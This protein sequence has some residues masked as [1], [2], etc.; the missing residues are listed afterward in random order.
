MPPNDKLIWDVG[1]HR[2]L[3]VITGEIKLNTA[4]YMAIYLLKDLKANFTASPLL[5]GLG[6]EKC[7]EI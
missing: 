6:M 1:H 5:A 4:Y 3:I 2:Y 7:S